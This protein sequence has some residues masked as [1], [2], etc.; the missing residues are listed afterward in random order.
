M[1]VIEIAK[2]Q[3]R[4]GQEN[5]TGV[6]QLDGGEFAWAADTEKLY[7]GLRRDDG[8]SRDTNVEILTENHLNNLF[9][10]TIAEH[11]YIYKYGSTSTTLNAS[12]ITAEDGTNDEFSRTVQQRLDDWVS[13]KNFGVYGNGVDWDLRKFQLAID[14]LFLNTGGYDPHPGTTLHVPA[15]IYVFTGTTYLPANTT[16]V[17][18][19]PGKTIFVLTTNSGALFKTMA[20][21]SLNG[22]N[23]LD[24]DGGSGEGVNF[25]ST[26][27]AVN[28]RI[29]GVTLTCDP[30]MTTVTDSLSLLSLDCADRSVIKNVEFVGFHV[31]GSVETTST[32]V[33]VNIRGKLA[34]GTNE[35]SIIKNCTFKNLYAGVSSN[36]DIKGTLIEDNKFYEL[37]RGVN[38]ND[39]IS[40]AAL[41]GPRLVKIRRNEFDMIEQQAI[42]VGVNNASTGS[43]IIST[44][45]IFDRVGYNQDPA[46]DTSTSATS[47]IAFLSNENSSINDYF[48][49]FQNQSELMN[50][51]GSTSTP[52]PAIIEGSALIDNAFVSTA[53]IEPGTTGTV[54]LRVPITGNSQHLD[55]KY[56][57]FR[58]N[59]GIFVTSATTD[60]SASFTFTVA[61]ITGVTI[62]A[63]TS[64][65]DIP[66]GSVVTDISL[67]TSEVTLD[68]EIISLTSGT[69][70]T[71]EF[72]LD[73]M[74]NLAV[75]LQDSVDPDT[76]VVD[77]YNFISGSFIGFDGGMTFDA[78]VNS[79]FTH[80]EV[81]A[82][83][84]PSVSVPVML[85]YQ[86]KLMI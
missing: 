46:G 69:E 75:Y 38:F 53:T 30:T 34:D 49:R 52:Y 13:V 6:P 20:L 42:Y 65:T 72:S 44:E 82:T 31:D 58:A 47:I 51:E 43:R 12:G 28:I 59:A 2:I 4:R 41:I 1:A 55:I 77:N 7:I 19:G 21:N 68:Q 27:S 70:V 10:Y 8:G 14:R 37:V 33:G 74:G 17:G 24:F 40:P 36:Y 57:A 71:F 35:N 76:I 62:G 26:S 85:E 81:Y 73:R 25:E 16:I 66:V 56:S 80:Y 5:Q 54:F 48:K 9:A 18:D 83:L 11:P 63:I 50:V 23:P 61:D 3:V 39:P 86:T 84:S 78:R 60:V 15:G 64:G 45:N 79:T 67:A 22:D 29:E 32:Y